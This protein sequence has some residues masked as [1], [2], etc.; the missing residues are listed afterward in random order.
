MFALAAFVAEHCVRDANARA[1]TY[2]AIE[3]MFVSQ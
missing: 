3:A 1:V 2:S